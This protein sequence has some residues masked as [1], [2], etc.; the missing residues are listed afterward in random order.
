MGLPRKQPKKSSPRRQ[1]RKSVLKVGLAK[2][3][4]AAQDAVAGA[5]LLRGALARIWA[6]ARNTCATD[7]QSE[8][9]GAVAMRLDESSLRQ[10]V[11]EARP[12]RDAHRALLKPGGLQKSL[13]ILQSMS[14]LR[15][16]LGFRF[17][18]PSEHGSWSME[19]LKG[20]RE[21]HVP[22]RQGTTDV[23]WESN[24][25]TYRL[26]RC[27]GRMLE[28]ARVVKPRTVKVRVEKHRP[29]MVSKGLAKE[30]ITVTARSRCNQASDKRKRIKVV[31]RTANL[32]PAVVVLPARKP[33]F[34]LIYLHGMG[35]SALGNYADRPHF[36]T[37]DGASVK[38]I[39][40]TAPLREVSCYDHW[41]EKKKVSPKQQS[42]HTLS[43][44]GSRQSRW[45]LATFRSWY[46]YTSNWD[47]RRE[48]DL[49]LES[50]H[51][52]QRALH[53]LIRREAKQ[54]GGRYDRVILGGKSQGCATALDAALTFPHKLG[55]FVGLVGHLL[56]CTPVDANGPQASTPLHFFHEPDDDI[57]RWSW[58]EATEQRMRDAGY[59][60][61][62]RHCRD[63]EGTGHFIGGVEGRWIRSALTA[64]CKPQ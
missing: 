4:P 49:D 9:L 38:V 59:N 11:A 30:M 33:Q 35:S 23:S 5:R 17:Q 48:D 60:V 61:Y 1:G 43:R 6:R 29:H 31:R 39:V 26:R 21:E 3:T 7:E 42:H 14:P 15:Q 47:G 8:R 45:R 20:F 56:A 36:F 10:W 44:K 24:V 13:T 22:R 46:D 37:T 19:N 57:I 16:S 63:P 52:M 18:D 55:G 40:P 12:K 34:T 53:S 58:V 32:L 62:S 28:I 27:K 54:L 25:A 2:K 50:L 64:I 41:W 51:A